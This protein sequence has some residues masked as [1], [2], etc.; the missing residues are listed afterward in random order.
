[1]LLVDLPLFGGRQRSEVNAGEASYSSAQYRK[2]DM[3]RMLRR[4]LE[5]AHAAYL[6]LGMRIDNYASNLI[7]QARANASAAL[8]AYQSDKGQFT[9]LMRARVME[10]ETGLQHLRLQTDQAKAR[11]ELIYLGGEK[12][13]GEQS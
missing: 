1:M 10:L 3:L 9:D 7:P 13:R 11:T 6:H 5:S 4:N 8:R 2:D 12:P